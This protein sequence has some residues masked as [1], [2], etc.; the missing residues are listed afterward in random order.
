MDQ[1][2]VSA[3]SRGTMTREKLDEYCNKVTVDFKAVVPA[4]LNRGIKLA[5]A[6]HSDTFE[7]V[8]FNRSPSIYLLGEELVEPVLRSSVGDLCNQFFIVAFNPTFRGEKNP[9]NYG[10]KYHVRAIA[11]HYGINTSDI[12]LFDD[13]PEN[14]RNVDNFH[15]F[16]VNP[17][18][19]FTMEDFLLYHQNQ[20]FPKK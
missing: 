15:V 11:K 20:D 2:L 7:N 16:G 14:L 5:V 17:E 3:H 18:T 1:T 4:L 10:K 6:T 19:G 9:E 12:L 8:Y 13:D